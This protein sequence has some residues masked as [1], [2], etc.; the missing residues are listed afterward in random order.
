MVASETHD[1][2]E[3]GPPRFRDLAQG[4]FRHPVHLGLRLLPHAL[5]LLLRERRLLP[6]PV[7]RLLRR[8]GLPACARRLDF[9]R[10]PSLR[11]RPGR[12]LGGGCPLHRLA[13]ESLGFF[14]ARG[15]AGE[16]GLERVGPLPALVAEEAHPGQDHEEKGEKHEGKTL[17]GGFVA[18]FLT[19]AEG[20]PKAVA[21]FAGRAGHGPRG[22][23]S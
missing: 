4:L 9:R 1:E 7:G 18:H 2:A 16:L 12:G 10:A 5:R 15:Q 3:S 22:P 13:G 20:R 21:R 17:G 11:C 8:L 14:G 19:I 6:L 23:R